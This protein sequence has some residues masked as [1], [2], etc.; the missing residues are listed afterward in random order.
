MSDDPM[1]IAILVPRFPPE[2]I[3]GMELASSTIAERLAI[4]GH[5]VHVVTRSHSA[6]GSRQDREGLYV[7]QLL[8]PRAS[9]LRYLIFSVK[10]FLVLRRI[11][12]DLVHVMGL[13]SGWVGYALKVNKKVPYLLYQRGSEYYQTNPLKDLI[14]KLGLQHADS[15]VTLTDYMRRQLQKTG[16][17]EVHV[18]PNGLNLEEF[19]DLTQS[20]CRAR[21]KIDQSA[22]IILYV[23]RLNRIK[24]TEYL[25]HAV[26]RIVRGQVSVPEKIRLLLVGKNQEEED[27]YQSL[28]RHLNIEKFVEFVGETPRSLIPVYMKAADL[29]VL[30]SLS[31]GF[32]NVILEAMASGLPIITTNVSGLPDIIRDGENGFI[33][34]PGDADQLAD[35]IRELICDD[36]L[37]AEFAERNEIEARSYNWDKI[38]DR[39]E[40]QYRAV[41]GTSRE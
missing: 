4:R 29:F 38:I 34:Q 6:T 23:G 2:F 12:P 9:V 10:S 7:H 35:R 21:L 13:G 32:P 19:T 18:I 20:G 28:A 3:A 40:Q 5:R 14:L 41:I 24:G 39:L 11:A 36:G 16:R 26:D 8:T 37:S 1:I 15:V 31:E 17:S 33:V 22:K 27:Y 25:L 30:P